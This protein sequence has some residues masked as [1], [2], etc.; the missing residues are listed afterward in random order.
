MSRHWCDNAM[1]TN[2]VSF[3]HRER[4]SAHTNC[5]VISSLSSR[6]Y[7]HAVATRFT[8]C[9]HL[10]RA[11][12]AP[13]FALR[14]APFFTHSCWTH[15]HEQ[16]VPTAFGTFFELASSSSKNVAAEC[17]TGRFG[18]QRRMGTTQAHAA[19]STVCQLRTRCGQ[20]PRCRHARP[21]ATAH[22]MES[23]S[24]GL[25]SSPARLN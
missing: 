23:Q 1:K 24:N 22:S 16:A 11:K 18:G 9:T 5:G 15:G 21:W 17:K 10:V 6:G 12:L 20:G 25:A 3:S 4:H 13:D 2:T 14:L 19:S 7:R 8:H